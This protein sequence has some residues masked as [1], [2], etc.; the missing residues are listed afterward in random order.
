MSNDTEIRIENQAVI[1][2]KI[3]PT[4]LFETVQEKEERYDQEEW[5]LL[6]WVHNSRDWSD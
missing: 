5:M 6:M 4:L 2:T 3:M 1:F